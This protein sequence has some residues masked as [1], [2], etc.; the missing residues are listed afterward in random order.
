MLEQAVAIAPGE[1][2]IGKA[3]DDPEFAALWFD[4][5]GEAGVDR[6]SW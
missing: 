2:L 3:H 6:Q 1:G 4:G 5:L